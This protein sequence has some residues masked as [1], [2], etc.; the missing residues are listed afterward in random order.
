MTL[1][2]YHAAD[3]RD[4]DKIRQRITSLEA[5]VEAQRARRRAV[6]RSLR[7]SGATVVDIAEHAGVTRQTVHHWATEPKEAK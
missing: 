3:L 4:L 6:L 1:Q 2:P 5:Q 7:E